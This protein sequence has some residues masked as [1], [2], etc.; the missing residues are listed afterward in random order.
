MPERRRLAP[1]E[2]ARELF[3]LVPDRDERAS[4]LCAEMLC[5]LVAN[6]YTTPNG[7]SSLRGPKLRRFAVRSLV[8]GENF[9]VQR[10]EGRAGHDDFTPQ[11]YGEYLAR[12]EDFL[13]SA[14]LTLARSALR[15]LVDP[16]T[17][18]RQPGSRLLLPFH[19]SLVWFDSRRTMNNPWTVRKVYMRGS[20]I[21]LAR[22]LLM[23]PDDAARE[24]AE[25]ATSLIKGALRADSPLAAIADQ[26]EGALTDEGA[27]PPLEQDEVE[28]WNFGAH[29][30]LSGLASA[31]PRHAEGVM[32]QGQASSP[33]R[34]WQLRTVLALDVIRHVVGTAWSVTETPEEHRYFLLTFGGGPRAENRVRHR[35][36][37][38]YQ[39]SR[40]RIKE[41]SVRTI[42][43]LMERIGDELDNPDWGA[44]FE[45]RTRLGDIIQELRGGADDY[46]SLA[47]RTFE[48]GSYDR[49]GDGFRVLLESIGMLA[50]T[51]AYRYLTATPDF[52]AAMVG[53]LSSEMPMES[54]EFF[55][56]VFAEWGI[57][58]SADAADCTSLVDEL[59]GA[60][61]ARN[62]ARAEQV[63]VEAGLA[64]ALSDRTTVVGERAARDA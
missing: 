42:E 63:M 47:R 43:S 58:I 1:G 27:H 35:S 31:V 46:P 40:I 23:A 12:G 64:I 57:V 28:A 61:M 44:E 48:G 21:T 10:E 34:L 32:A 45:A 33:A 26:L 30:R 15:G 59:E 22:L 51:G 36:E 54:H 17:E 13:G 37:Q 29:P 4:Q 6:D 20:G 56:R 3:G 50:G 60:E 18:L 39:Q 7:E 5:M 62:Q 2:V 14:N 52:L 25:M 55:K 16:S 19:E 11:R 38:S 53:A 24:L 8:L 9:L 41:A 49:S